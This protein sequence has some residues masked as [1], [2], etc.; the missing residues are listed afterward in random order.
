[1]EDIRK[2]DQYICGDC[3]EEMKKMED[4][5]INFVFTSPPYADQVKDYGDTYVKVKTND[6]CDWFKPRAEQIYRVLKSNGSFVLNI[7]DKLDGK[8]QSTYVFKMVL[9]L[10][11]EIGFHLVRDYIWFNPATPPNIFSK[12]GL[13]RTKKSHEY[14]FWFSKGEEWIFNMDAIRKPYSQAMNKLLEGKTSTNR[15][16]NTRPSGHTFDLSHAWQDC[17]GADPGSVV[18]VSNTTSNGT[19]QKVA[20]ALNIKHPARFPEKLA[21]FFILAGTNEGDVVLDPFGGS[22]TTA[23]VA[24]KLNRHFKYIE[25]NPDY[26][27]LAKKW[28]YV[29][30]NQKE[31]SK[32][33]IKKFCEEM[34][35]R[36][37][38]DILPITFLF[39]CYRK[40]MKT[41]VLYEIPQTLK[42]F[43]IGLEDILKE[44]SYGWSD[45]IQNLAIGNRM[46]ICEPIIQ[47]Y[48]LDS[49]YNISKIDDG[50]C[51]DDKVHKK[52]RGIE[53]TQA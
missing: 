52:I 47:E 44:D 29:E 13:G 38:W 36:F 37:V 16:H 35:G 53:R 2:I 23:I 26:V 42:E 18:I 30:N 40:W 32:Q 25:I 43:E 4:E 51:I 8:F 10:T 15:E 27:E 9:M 24:K 3:L 19:F 1:M 21:E 34:L 33:N 11:E 5:S 7:N 45:E 20:S 48:K 14:C 17:G 50:I 49:W 12:G 6:F 22:G 31:I 28:N 46:D 41:G 39:D